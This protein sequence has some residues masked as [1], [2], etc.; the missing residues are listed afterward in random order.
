MRWSSTLGSPHPR[1]VV[2]SSLLSLAV[3]AGCT[4]ELGRSEGWGMDSGTDNRGDG[5]GDPDDP[6]Q[7]DD[8]GTPGTPAAPVPLSG[9][10]AG[11]RTLSASEYRL[12]ARDL[13]G[14]DVF[15]DT[16]LPADTPVNGFTSLGSARVAFSAQHVESFEQLSYSAAEQVFDD[17]ALRVEFVGCTPAASDD[18]CVR[19]FLTRFA[20]K[21]FRRAATA[22]EIDVYANL[23]IAVAETS[24]VWTG[25]AYAVAAF[26]QSP[27]FLY[28]VELGTPED[29][30]ATERQLTAYE[31]A[32]RLAY[33]VT[34]TAPGDDLLDAAEAGLLDDEVGL[35]GELERLL[36]LPEAEENLVRFWAQQLELGHIDQMVKV[37]EVFPAFTPE[38]AASMK[39]EMYEVVS[40]L[41]W[42]NPD[43]LLTLFSTRDTFVNSTL[44]D[45]YGVS[46]PASPDD[47][48]AVTWP[49]GNP[50]A[51]FLSLGGFLASHAGPAE[52]SV[53]K[54]GYFVVSK[55][56]C[57]EIPS[58]PD[59]VDTLLPSPPAGEHLTMRE[60]V[61]QHMEDPECNTCHSLMDPPGLALEHFDALGVYRE[62]DGGLT[63]DATGEIDGN[64][65]DGAQELGIV[66]SDHSGVAACFSRRF[67]EFALGTQVHA[68]A[69]LSELQSA[70]EESG[71]RY[72]ELVRALVSHDV[73]RLV[74]APR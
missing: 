39:R 51:G 37:P 46:G 24:D 8:M 57:K 27:D 67:Y 7:P 72:P 54:R 21:A 12:S 49:E 69:P 5:L 31:V 25:L 48:E 42:R 59:G 60:R 64:P 63:I 13:L 2:G 4:E 65:F 36:L 23:V 43:D 56:L 6:N 38:L 15:Q 22:E 9:P 47:W 73:F 35:L 28:R 30:A 70:F 29:A 1:Q 55:L 71:R 52:T 74:S 3:L 44:A 62:N 11:L 34:G 14:A 45:F 53:T 18:P 16:T 61:E 40:D 32:T 26:L 50:R 58:P 68:G 20:R 19:E 33:L 66:L 17:E 41:A 10:S